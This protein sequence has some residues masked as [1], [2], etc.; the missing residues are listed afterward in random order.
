MRVAV[1]DSGV[2][3]DHPH[4]GGVAGGIGLDDD[5]NLVADYLDRLGHGTA[6]TAVIREKAPEAELFAV[7]VFDRQLQATGVA[8]AR[9]LAWAVD[10][11]VDLINLSLGT[12]N[13]AHEE[14][15]Q[16]EVRRASAAGIVVVSAAPD[17]ERR[18]LP[19]ALPDVVRVTADATLPRDTVRPR[20][21]AQDHLAVDASPF[22]RPIPGVP[23]ERNLHGTSFAVANVTGM[24]AKHWPEWPQWLHATSAARHHLDRSL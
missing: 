22:P 8:L 20:S 10:Q 21:Q 1:I 17:A 3:A 9:A 24:L 11:P 18:W 19:G 12:L 14:A 4:V 15:L 5:G 23:P 13:S 7:K 16:R 2:H 6:V